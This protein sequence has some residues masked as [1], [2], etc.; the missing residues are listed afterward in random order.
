MRYLVAVLIAVAFLSASLAPS[1]ALAGKN[2]EKVTMDQVPAPVK[3]TIE[4]EAKGAGVA[5][6]TKESE[7]GRTYYEA[8]IKQKGLDRYVQVAPDG[9]VIKRL[10]A[11]EEMKD[12]MK[13][14][15]D[16]K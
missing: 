15:T 4:K 2:G 16:K 3:A 1:P 9:K 6:I 5:D 11:K 14:K 10:S 13:G 12:E 7:N 8:Q